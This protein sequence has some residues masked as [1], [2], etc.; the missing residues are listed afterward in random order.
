[1][2]IKKRWERALEL[3]VNY[4]AHLNTVVWYRK[5]YLESVGKEEWIPKFKEYEGKVKIL[6]FFMK[7]ILFFVFFVIFKVTVDWESIK[8]EIKKEKEK[9]AKL[10]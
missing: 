3:A 9:E 5:R 2:L 1:M 7:F 10:K 8:A 6:N 4:K